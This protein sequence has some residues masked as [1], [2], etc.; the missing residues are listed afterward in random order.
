MILITGSGVQNISALT[1]NGNGTLDVGNN[2]LFINYGSGADPINTI[3]QY[4]QQGFN[5]GAWNGLG[6]IDTSAAQLFPSYTLGY[7]DSADPGNPAGLASGQIEI[8]FTLLGDA[9]LDGSVNGSDF[10]ILAANFNKAVNGWDQGDFNY[11][12]A[13]NGADFAN[14][15][16]NFNRGASQSAVSSGDGTALDTFA[17]TNGLL[18]D[19]PEPASIGLALM[20]ASLLGMRRRKRVVGTK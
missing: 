7:A 16:A 1:I 6:G 18:A 13:V 14:L 3:K 19:V 15:A 11:D 9:N 8:K 5:A 2:H 17:A 20:G 10:A 4:L 12:G